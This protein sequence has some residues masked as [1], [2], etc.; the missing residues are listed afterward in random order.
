MAIAYLLG[1]WYGPGWLWVARSFQKWIKEIQETFS[2][3]ILLKTWFAPWKQIQSPSS[4]RYFL[5]SAIDNF[6]SRFIG[7]TVRTGM[8]LLAFLAIAFIAVSGLITLV[9]WPFVPLLIIAL[10]LSWVGKVHF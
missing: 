2:V 5:Q 1:W 8:L 7:A 3:S 6:I 9:C 10:P 4:F